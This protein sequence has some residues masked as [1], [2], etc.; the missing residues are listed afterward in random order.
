MRKKID[1]EIQRGQK[2]GSS[3]LFQE[4]YMKN[5]SGPMSEGDHMAD[6]SRKRQRKVLT[7]KRR[8]IHE[9]KR[10]TPGSIEGRSS[11]PAGAHREGKQWIQTIEKQVLNRTKRI[12][13]K[14]LKKQ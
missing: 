4:Q 3:P 5:K 14:L 6:S 9:S 10:T 13:K 7:K 8:T 12:T 11:A 2:R 1:K